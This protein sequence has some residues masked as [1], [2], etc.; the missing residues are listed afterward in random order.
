MAMQ[1]RLLGLLLLTPACT[2]YGPIGLDPKTYDTG[3]DTASV[4]SSS[5]D[6]AGDTAVAELAPGVG[7]LVITEI[8]KDPDLID[9][10]LGEWFEVLNASGATL[11]LEGVLVQDDD[12]DAF[13]L[14]GELA[15]GARLVL[16]ASGD[17][18]Q[19]G[20]I[21]GA[22]AW[23]TDTFKLKNDE[24]QIVLSL[25]GLTLDAVR[26]DADFPDD[27]ARA[28]SLDP[29]ETSAVQNDDEDAWCNADSYYGSLGLRGTPGSANDACG[30]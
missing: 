17:G 9:G 30:G 18:A 6:S 2:V 13:A 15:S 21:E 26:Y 14:T 1:K 7:D 5:E 25:S 8:M 28:T 10:D 22:V 16:A 19:N 27:P 23:P 24:D 29:A 12:A 11:S 3:G 20:G 4:D